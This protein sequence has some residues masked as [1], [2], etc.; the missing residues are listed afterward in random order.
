MGNGRFSPLRQAD[1]GAVIPTLYAASTEREAIAKFYCVTLGRDLQGAL[2]MSSPIFTNALRAVNL[3][4]NG[5]GRHRLGTVCFLRQTKIH[6]P[7]TRA[8]A[9]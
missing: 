3:D 7:R 1:T 2:H 4:I 9:L 6:L 5:N 8:R